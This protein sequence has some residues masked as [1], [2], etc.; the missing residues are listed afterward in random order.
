MALPGSP[1]YSVIVIRNV[2]LA[3]HQD[4][5]LQDYAIDAGDVD[6][7]GQGDVI[8]DL[9]DGRELP[10]AISNDR[11][12]P[13]IAMSVDIAPESDT[14]DPTDHATSSEV[15]TRRIKQSGE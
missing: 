13:E 12:K 2:N 9:D 14:A 10:S 7:I 1:V 6:A 8:A 3:A 5:T 4:A 11:L 15:K